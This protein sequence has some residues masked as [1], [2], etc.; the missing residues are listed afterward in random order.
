VSPGAECNGRPRRLISFIATIR[1]Q[2]HQVDH[3]DH[4]DYHDARG[5]ED[6]RIAARVRRARAAEEAATPATGRTTSERF[7]R[8]A[9]LGRPAD[10]MADHFPTVPGL[11]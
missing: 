11:A 4:Y 8:G 7:G 3:V 9:P 5:H 10:D 6:R 2:A 1:E